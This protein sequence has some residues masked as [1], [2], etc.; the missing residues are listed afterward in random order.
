V[1]WGPD[2]HWLGWRYRSAAIIIFYYCFPFAAMMPISHA[3]LDEN[4]AANTQLKRR[5]AL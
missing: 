1:S 4:G 2:F 5:A 3:A